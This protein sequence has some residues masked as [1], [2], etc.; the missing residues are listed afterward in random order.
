MK[1]LVK[2]HRKSSQMGLEEMSQSEM[3]ASKEA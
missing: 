1:K 3:N 2:G